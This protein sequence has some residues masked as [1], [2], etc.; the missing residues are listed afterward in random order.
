[1]K[2]YTIVRVDGD[3]PLDDSVNG[4]PWAD[5]EVFRVDEFC[6]HESGPKPDTRGRAIYD[7]D[8]LYL[9][10]EVEDDDIS[11]A[12]TE[13]NGPTFEDS[14]VEFFA[15]PAP[16]A[17]SKYFNFEPNCCGQ[18]KLGWQEKDWQERGIGRDV[19]SEELAADIEIRT[20]VPGPTKQPSADDAGWWLAAKLPFDALSA[21]TGIDLAPTA[22][23][24]WRGNFY[25]SGVASPSQKST[26][27]PIETPEPRYHSPEFFGRLVFG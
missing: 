26:W 6:W 19:V 13:L 8:A 27:N 17:D 21:F 1:M 9:Q 15:D 24:E 7:D 25:R 4:T 5:G 12:V 23:A 11:A 2:T 10:F 14:S 3:V 20:S 18:F 22:G 16:D